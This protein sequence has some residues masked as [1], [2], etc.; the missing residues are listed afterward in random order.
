MQ[1]LLRS[2]FWLNAIENNTEKFTYEHI[3]D[4]SSKIIDGE[5][6]GSL[7]GGDLNKVTDFLLD[8]AES[9][10]NESRKNN[11]KNIRE[12]WK[13]LQRLSTNVHRRWN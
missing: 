10:Q 13:N 7:G 12:S 1:E 11:Y 6:R 4:L 9:T 2:V 5:Y 3:R 8:E